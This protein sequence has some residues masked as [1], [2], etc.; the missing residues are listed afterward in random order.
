[1]HGDIWERG[2]T[3]LHIV[4]IFGMEVQLEC[5][6]LHSLASQRLEMII[7]SA[8]ERS[9]YHTYLCD[10]KLFWLPPPPRLT[11]SFKLQI[12]DYACVVNTGSIYRQEW[13]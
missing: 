7:R 11:A 6:M 13:V 10:A 1:M 9:N 8:A 12:T 4:E 5:Y 2:A 3:R